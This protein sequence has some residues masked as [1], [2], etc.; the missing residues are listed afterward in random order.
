VRLKAVARITDA[1]T[2]R[3]IASDSGD[4]QL[5]LTAACRLN[6]APLIKNIA[7]SA[8]GGNI[9]LEAAIA[10]GDQSCLAAIALNDW[11]ISRGLKAVEEITN[12]LLLRRVTR[13]AKQDAI[14]L[15]AAIKLANPEL[16]KDVA[17]SSNHI[18]I[19]WQ[20]A[21]RLNDPQLLAE[22][23][24]FKPG[25]AKMA[26]L[27]RKA[28]NA[29]MA[30]LDRCQEKGD[31]QALLE[32]MTSVPHLTTKLEAFV[33][34]P[35]AVITLGL[36]RYL[37]LQD[38]RYVPEALRETALAQIR[39]GG[40]LVWSAYQ[41]QPCIHCHGSGKLSLKCISANNIW[42]DRDMFPCPECD[43]KGKNMVKLVTC[44]NKNSGQ[45]AFRFPK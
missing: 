32:A 44:K 12:A 21:K 26:P 17:R 27:R 28:K 34:L 2:L 40:W 16:L 36:L 25:N 33:R 38:F 30:Y 11:V 45:V 22:I 10:A 39:S 15:A 14:R 19:H 23:V 42:S 20:V 43:G 3:R 9:R 8:T 7:R 41:H 37:A 18:D 6:D 13:S 24:H 31:H 1:K 35:A 29:L 4:E 5:R